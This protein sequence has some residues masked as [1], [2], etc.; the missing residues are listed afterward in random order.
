MIIISSYKTFRN[1][2]KIENIYNGKARHSQVLYI[3]T[4]ITQLVNDKYIY[5][6]NVQK[7]NLVGYFQY[8]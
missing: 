8:E 3:N 7:G 2:H 5:N 6:Y 1:S 4:S